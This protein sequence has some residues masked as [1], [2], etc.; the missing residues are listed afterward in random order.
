MKRKNSIRI[1]FTLCIL[2]LIFF[3]FTTQDN[4]WQ[5]E[6]LL[7]PN[8]LVSIL[9]NPKAK[10]PIILNVGPTELI[11]SAKSMGICSTQ[12]GIEQFKNYVDKLP[13]NQDL[14]I[15]CG[16]CKLATCPN[17]KKTMLY[18]QLR[19]YT[20][21]KLLDLPTSLEVDW[22]KKGYPMD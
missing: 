20:N 21:Y 5:K 3:A 18:L 17:I 10:K 19:G 7:E 22:I 9:N 12:E 8:T 4:P 15:Y 14:V 2:P 6:Q 13:L 1:I 16:C 11:K